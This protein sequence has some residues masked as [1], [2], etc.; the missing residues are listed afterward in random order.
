V[1]NWSSNSQWAHLSPNLW[2]ACQEL[3][4]VA[5]EAGITDPEQTEPGQVLAG[6]LGRLHQLLAVRVACVDIQIES[7]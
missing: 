2:L 6:A 5:A 1:R 3:A 4:V 7:L